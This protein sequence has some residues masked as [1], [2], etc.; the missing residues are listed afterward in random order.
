VRSL[1]VSILASMAAFGLSSAQAV[2][3]TFSISPVRVDLATPSSTGVVT[4]RNQEDQPVVV[5]AEAH[6]WQQG[7][8]GESLTPSRDVL[9]TPAV[10]TIPPQG[11]QVVRVALRRA[12]DPQFELSYRLILTEV[13]QQGSPQFNGL[14]M[15]LQISLPVFVAAQARTAPKLEWRASRAT[16]GAIAITAGNTGTEHARVLDLKVAPQPGRGD[17]IHQQGAYYVLPGQSK[18]WTLELDKNND[19]AQWQKLRVKG[20]TEDGDF[21]TE[22]V[23]AQE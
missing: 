4:L 18:R 13:P 19:S 7:P 1:F 9:V 6:L 21:S 15:A 14:N 3:G 8:D 5:Q 22:L 17:W 23:L 16:D 12:P 2:A 11:S 10:F 20:T